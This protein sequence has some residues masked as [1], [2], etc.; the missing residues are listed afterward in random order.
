[1]DYFYHAM[2]AAEWLTAPKLP[3]MPAW[4]ACHFSPYGTGLS[5][6]PKML[7]ADALIM[8]S[9]RI[10]PAGHDA[11]L[12]VS[13]LADLTAAFKP[14]AIVLDLEAPENDFCRELARQCCKLKNVEVAVASRYAQDLPCSVFLSAAQLWTK[15][16]DWLQPWEGRTIW[17]ESVLQRGLVTVT[18]EGAAYKEL[19]W[20]E[21][22]EGLAV[23]EELQVAYR[24][25]ETKDAVEVMLWRG[26]KELDTWMQMLKGLGIS[27]FLGLYQQLR[28]P[29]EWI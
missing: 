9:D 24:I 4:M 17:A 27:R 15:P 2:T 29:E 26:R 23:D 6:L 25:R 18:D 3:E 21:P 8:V 28:N 19:P 22:E 10:S 7:P 5:N 11:A 12:M 20:E 13:Q 1:M 16:E 14:A